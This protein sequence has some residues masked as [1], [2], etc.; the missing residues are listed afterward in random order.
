MIDNLI[1]SLNV[2]LPM[3]LMMLLGYL[4]CRIRLA[5]ENFMNK[6]SA[7]TFRIFLPLL[8]FINLYNADHTAITDWPLILFSAAGIIL[9]Y[10]ITWIGVA[11]IE[12]D[13]DKRGVMIQGIFRSN[14][15]IF[16]MPVL[17]GLFG[18]AGVAYVSAMMLVITPLF[19]TGSVFIFSAY[20]EKRVSIKHSMIAVMK[21]PLIIGTGLGVLALFSGIR[22]PTFLERTVTDLSRVATPLAIIA[23]GGTFSFKSIVKAKRQL[24]I[25]MVGRLLV[26]PLI[27]LPIGIALGMRDVRLAAL[28]TVFAS[29]TAVSSFVVAKQAGA[30]AQLAGNIVVFTSIASIATVFLFIFLLRQL[31]FM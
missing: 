9:S 6:L 1:V 14:T 24:V 31:G 25:A 8:L 2:V 21:N 19:N 12:K 23:L 22:F 15:A 27:F 20:S 11:L 10:A 28:V 26:I 4:M 29:P 30:D 16:G 17:F 3:F 7:V 5:D 13:N 18:D